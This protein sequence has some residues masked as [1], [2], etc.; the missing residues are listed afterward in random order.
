MGEKCVSASCSGD[1]YV[2]DP[3]DHRPKNA[4]SDFI[5]PPLSC[6]PC[7]LWN[8]PNGQKR[9]TIIVP[10]TNCLQTVYFTGGRQVWLKKRVGVSAENIEAG[11]LCPKCLEA[12]PEEKR[13]RA[14]AASLTRARLEGRRRVFAGLAQ[15]AS[16]LLNEALSRKSE[17]FEYWSRR[18]AGA[19][20]YRAAE[21]VRLFLVRGERL[22]LMAPALHRI[23]KSSLDTFIDRLERVSESSRA[24]MVALLENPALDHARL[25]RALGRTSWIPEDLACQ[26]LR[27]LPAVVARAPKASGLFN[28]VP[29]H[30]GKGSSS[31]LTDMETNTTQTAPRMKSSAPP[32]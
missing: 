4:G 16:A 5:W 26:V 1:H 14:E 24:G 30:R 21:V 31:W 8:N 2:H 3:P 15:P 6:K 11:R 12:S 22:Q 32:L 19:V 9:K 29:K 18:L 23:D 7:R 27:A 10:C 20:S 28:A 13:A 17:S 25:V